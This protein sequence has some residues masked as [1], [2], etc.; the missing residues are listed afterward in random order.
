[1]EINT[2]TKDSLEV[3]IIQCNIKITEHEI[4]IFEQKKLVELWR[5]LKYEKEVQLKRL[6]L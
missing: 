5:E 1:M 3:S 2:E 4:I 6:E